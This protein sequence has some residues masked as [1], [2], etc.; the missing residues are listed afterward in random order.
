M[1]RITLGVGALLAAVVFALGSVAW[2]GG[3]SQATDPAAQENVDAVLGTV[4]TYQGNLRKSG[5]P[6]N[7]NCSL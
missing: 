2:A 3:L 6:V 4:F 5:Q 7:D 1:M